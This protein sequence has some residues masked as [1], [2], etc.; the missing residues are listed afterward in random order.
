MYPL[1]GKGGG[2]R[3]QMSHSNNSINPKPRSPPPK[4]KKQKQQ[5]ILNN[6]SGQTPPVNTL[7]C[8]W[9]ASLPPSYTSVQTVLTNNEF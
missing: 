4:K 5:G 3:P 2:E 7:T 8:Q 6:R 1:K 9:M